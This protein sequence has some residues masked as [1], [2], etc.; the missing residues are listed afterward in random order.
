MII[1]RRYTPADL[2]AVLALFYETVHTVN[3][4]D[5]APAQ[6]D[7]WAPRQPDRAAWAARLAAEHVLLAEEGSTLLGF[8]SLDPARG[9]LDHLYVHHAHQ[10]CG[11]ATRLCEALAPLAET[12][13]LRAEVSQ[14][15][16][17]FFAARGWRV[18]R[19]QE[20][21]RDGAR[22]ENMVMEKRL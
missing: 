1:L 12:P 6:L 14:T 19:R 20:V 18:V 4:R 3:A 15:A 10:R 21:V 11:I 8:A 22:L 16:T 13:V 17:P 5:Y 7:A 9:L 2:E